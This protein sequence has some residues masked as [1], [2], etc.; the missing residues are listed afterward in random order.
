MDDVRR[1]IPLPPGHRV[2]GR[3]EV[4]TATGLEGRCWCPTPQ[5]LERLTRSGA[6]VPAAPPS[7]VLHR[8]NERGF[9][10]ELRALPEALRCQDIDAIRAAT[11]RPGRWLLF[12]ALTFAGR[13]QRRVDRGQWS[14]T[15]E[16]W[17]RVSL[18]MGA[19]YVLPRVEVELEVSLHGRIE[20]KELRVGRPTLSSVDANGQWISARVSQDELS[21]QEQTSLQ[22]AFN[23]AARALRTAGYFGP[24]G[25]D[26]FRHTGGFHPLSEINAR[27]SMGWPVGMGG[28]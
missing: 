4:D 27:Y 22:D 26:A 25:I 10:H 24:F 28:W 3:G 9:A 7:S 5:A 16:S 1:S 17:S 18:R 13:G 2:L 6:S 20:G 23:D 21:P 15:D 12:R 8:V 11:E 14:A 19:V